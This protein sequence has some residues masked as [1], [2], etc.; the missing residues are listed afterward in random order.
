MKKINVVR[1][2]RCDGEMN[3]LFF[4]CFFLYTALQLFTEQVQ[5]FRFA[6]ALNLLLYMVFVPGF[7]FLLGYRFG[8]NLRTLPMED[9]K[10]SLLRA[11]AR[12]LG[13]FFFLAMGQELF[14]RKLPFN[15]V[16][17]ELLT[18]IYI[19]AVS[20][21]FFTMALTLVVVWIFYDGICRC[22]KDKKKMT[23]LA[24]ICLLGAF[25]WTEQDTYAV[26]AAVTGSSF[27]QAVPG[28]PYFAFFLFGLWIE[29]KKP[30]FDLKLFGIT[31][32]VTVVSAVLYRTPLQ[33]LCRVTISALPVYL[34]YAAAEFLSDVTLRVKAAKF[35]STTVERVYLIYTAILFT[36]LNFGI[37]DGRGW[38]MVVFAAAGLFL[39]L[40]L[41]IFL[42]N[43]FG[44]IYAK[45]ANAFESR[46]RHKTAVYFLLYT[47]AFAVLLVL[48]FFEFIHLDKSF[49]WVGDGVTQYYP[50]ALYFCQYIR[51]LVSN[52]LS[53]NFTLPMYDFTLGFGTEITYSLEPL[54]FLYA[55][56]G[57]E[58]IEFTYNL[59]TLL[60]FYLAGITSSILML[61]F[62]KGYFA[63]FLGSVVY[64]FSGFALYGGAKHT[65]F[66]IPMIMLPLLIISMEEII[67]KRRWY[68]CTIFV[69]ISLFSNYYY[70]YMNTIAMGIYFVVRFGC[71]KEKKD[72]TIR[73]FIQRGL[74]ICGSYLLGVGMSCIVL[75]TTFGLYLGSGRS[76]SFSIHTPSLFFY[77][78]NRMVRT[79][80]T[81]ITTANSPGDWLKL[82]Y[83]P[84]AL[85]AVVFLFL[86]KG[87]K[88]LKIFCAVSVAFLAFPAAGF[89][90]S[91]F[92]AVINRWCYMA[93]L[94]VGF[95]VT[96][97]YE[98][99]LHLKKRD[100]YV[101]GGVVAVYGFLVFFGDIQI[102]QSTRY[103]K[104]AF[105]FLAVT[106]LVLVFCQESYKKLTKAAKQ[107]MMFF[108]TAALVFANGY[109]E[110]AMNEEIAAY[111]DNGTTHETIT[112]TPLAALEQIEDDSFYRSAVT[113]LDYLTSSASLLLDFNPITMV[114][115]TLNGCISE[116]ME[117]M[118]CTSYSTTQLMG[119][120]NRTYL[121]A[122]AAVK[123]YGRYGGQRA[124]PYGYEEVL[125]TEVNDKTAKI[126]ENQYAL[127][128]GYTYSEAISEEE[129]EQYDV[130]ERQEV[131]MQKVVLGDAEAGGNTGVKVTGERA[132]ITSYEEKGIEY[133]ENAFTAGGERKKFRL[134]LNFEGLE[135]SETYLVF[136]NAAAKGDTDSYDVELTAK[137]N[138]N[139]VSY[140]FQAKNYRYASGQS[141]YVINLGY[142]EEALTS[143]T[144]WMD[145]AG[146]LTFDDFYIY[147]QPMDN[148]EKYTENL[149]QNV[150]EDIVIDTNR[151]SGTISL[152][153]DKYLVLSIPYQNGW[154]AYV[155][156]QQAELSR[157]NYMYVALELDAGEHT[158]ELNFE[159][160]AVKY[161]LAIM[162]A[163]VVLFTGLCLV[164]FIRGKAK[165]K[166]SRKMNAD[167]GNA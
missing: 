147:C 92:S 167:S 36:V 148:T 38:K 71:Q 57:E 116:Y 162:A 62:K 70:L 143:C 18:V 150:L 8:W 111:K 134:N 60:R 99:M 41:F 154:T 132:R 138:D 102:T 136:K 129:L 123:Y 35:V 30:G 61:Y 113:Q 67:R 12:C 37:L 50:R 66:M 106:M 115:S 43:Q 56:F 2:N 81:F 152:D 95:I 117:K 155:D 144:I 28:L 69:A 119:L 20:A 161:A 131:M 104:M 164:T 160:P 139:S 91:G 133:T 47:A 13:Y 135:N 145:A 86:R 96:E 58:H 151:V 112:D 25:L 128:L 141:D 55:L 80:L 72:R 153:E 65:M 24:V 82:G 74:V 63:T 19:P 26:L 46:T 97:C 77:S 45:A 122:L 124:L 54:Y 90:F 52:F 94:L 127:P 84:I 149:T 1:Q 51:E 165:K 105:V 130:P 17:T 159:I 10:K 146:S 98:E 29:D 75:A 11:A 21:V 109:T 31:A 120:G 142:S 48:V 126:S 140:K 89:V 88:E 114:N 59:V 166:K 14:Q 108:L 39:F 157:A 9:A 44:E 6:N 3:F 27:H 78:V 49:I 73:N 40:Y 42:F 101:L 5:T 15:Y 156:G 110:F 83:L 64:V 4:G 79:F 16:L 121:N 163:S 68:L 93:S 85:L 53:G 158:I 32:G 34:V 33:E 125:K 137:A 76:G 23:A 100:V 118:G 87:R 107:C 22:L 7:L 103:T